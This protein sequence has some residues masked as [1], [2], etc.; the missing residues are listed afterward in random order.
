MTG[1]LDKDINAA[2]FRFTDTGGKVQPAGIMAKGFDVDRA[3]VNVV[4]PV[5]DS[6]TASLVSRVLG[7]VDGA[8]HAGLTKPTP[9]KAPVAQ[10]VAPPVRDHQAMLREQGP[11]TPPPREVRPGKPTKP[12][13]A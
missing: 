8:G 12:Y 2:V 1:E 11:T 3:N 5:A 13:L 9:R 10:T 7:G 4:M 6:R